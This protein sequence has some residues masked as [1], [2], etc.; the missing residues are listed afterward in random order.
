MNA[1]SQP[2]QP[3]RCV[4]QQANIPGNPRCHLCL[5]WKQ[6]DVCVVETCAHSTGLFVFLH[7]SEVCVR[8]V[9]GLVSP[10]IDLK[11]RRRVFPF[12]VG[13]SSNQHVYKEILWRAL[14]S[15]HAKRQGN[16]WLLHID[17]SAHNA[18]SCDRFWEYPS[19]SA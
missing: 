1:S 8:K 10:K 9:P 19:R 6:A 13:Q 2:A 14:R 18:H 15:V 16:S 11:S 4:L 17:A 7:A 12:A 3:P 5:H